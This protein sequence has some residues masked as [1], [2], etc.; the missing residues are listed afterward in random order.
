MP[1]TPT[2]WTNDSLPY[3]DQAGLNNIEA[4]VAA[5]PYGPDALSGYFPVA[6]GS[7]GWSYRRLTVADLPSAISIS[8]LSGYPGDVNK[9]LRGDGTWATGGAVQWR[10]GSGVPSNGLGNDGDFYLNTANGDVYSKSSGSWTLQGNIKGATGATGASG[11]AN[12]RDIV[13]V[14]SFSSSPTATG[15]NGGIW[16]APYDGGNSKTWNLNR[17]YLRAEVGPTTGLTAS[18]EKSVAGGA[19][20]ATV[21]RALSLTASQNE[22]SST[23]A[24]GT[25]S[26]GNLLRVNFTGADSVTSS[27]PITVQLEGQATS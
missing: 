19:F 2:V 4:G 1:Y 12:L 11:S 23:S 20:S 27:A 14:W 17:V 7:G 9:V 10:S 21:I 18:I 8:L 13:V 5:A 6:N 16:Q 15:Q 26:S 24:L 3:V 25:I 22:A